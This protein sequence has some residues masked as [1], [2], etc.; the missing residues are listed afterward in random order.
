MSKIGQTTGF[1]M[2]EDCPAI[3]LAYQENRNDELPPM[4][5]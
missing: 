5:Q 4:P 2:T 3:K 1:P